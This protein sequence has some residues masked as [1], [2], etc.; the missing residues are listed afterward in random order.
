MDN[1]KA[2]RPRSNAQNTPA[3]D[4]STSGQSQS[5]SQSSSCGRP[6]PS[7]SDHGRPPGSPSGSRQGQ[8]HG[9]PSGSPSG[10]GQGGAPV[11]QPDDSVFS[12]DAPCANEQVSVPRSDCSGWVRG[13]VVS[14]KPAQHD[15]G[16]L[17]AKVTAGNT[18]KELPVAML[19][20]LTQGK[21]TAAE[22]ASSADV[23]HTIGRTL[24][25]PSS[26]ATPEKYPLV[27][28]LLSF[29]AAGLMQRIL[30]LSTATAAAGKARL[31]EAEQRHRATMA[32]KERLKQKLT[33]ATAAKD[34]AE[35]KLGDAVEQKQANQQ[36]AKENR[37]LQAQAAQSVQ[38][39]ETL[40]QQ[41]TAANVAKD[42]A[43]AKVGDAAQEK[44]ALQRQ[45]A[46]AT[47]ANDAA[48]VQLGQARRHIQDQ[49]AASTAFLGETA[50]GA[51]S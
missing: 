4:S 19:A 15:G 48:S 18:S 28:D 14:T 35:A 21:V 27:H 12:F 30:A 49:T 24:R 46:A 37:Q 41:L 1:S 26:P 50:R 44:E 40:Q 23:L 16:I 32:E 3:P 47:D 22:L 42:A 2:K 9:R 10:S 45:L 43:A 20:R 11:P 33:A 29:E 36:L 34:A 51:S 5:Q 39:K 8:G 31:E 25:H 38:E 17:M 7:G 13:M 6:S